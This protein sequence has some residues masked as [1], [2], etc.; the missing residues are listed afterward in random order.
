M[1]ARRPK[2]HNRYNRYCPHNRHNPH[3]WHIQKPRGEFAIARLFSRLWLTF[4]L[5]SGLPR[6]DR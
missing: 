6:Q 1:C 5:P 3:I 4:F 2:W